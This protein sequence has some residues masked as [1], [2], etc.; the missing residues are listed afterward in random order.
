VRIVSTVEEA[1][2]GTGEPDKSTPARVLLV[3]G[4][5]GDPQSEHRYTWVED[6]LSRLEGRETRDA[7]Y[8][9]LEG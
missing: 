6:Y 7:Y 2:P 3:T 1:K 5:S 9:R 8:M 4:R